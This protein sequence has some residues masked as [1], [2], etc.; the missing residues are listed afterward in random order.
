VARH[1]FSHKGYENTNTR[2][3]A[4]RAG[5]GVGTLFV[6]FP[7]KRDLLFHLFQRDVRKLQEAS[8]SELPT[9]TVVDRLMAVFTRYFDYY[10]RDLRLSR[11]FIKELPFGGDVGTPMAQLVIHFIGNLA[12]IIDDGRRG[13]TIDDA[14]EPLIAAYQCF[15]SYYMTLVSWLGGAMPSRDAQL[16]VLRRLL[17]LQYRGL[18][19]ITHRS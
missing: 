3:I 13:G 4:Q 15:A 19:P 18:A 9:G 5:I 1:R 10:E 6:Y 17:D 11:A 2:E 12:R 14:V 7:E 16:A 8:F